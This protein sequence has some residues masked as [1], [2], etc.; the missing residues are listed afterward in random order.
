MYVFFITYPS[1]TNHI[2]YRHLKLADKFILSFRHR[3]GINQVISFLISLHPPYSSLLPV[4]LPGGSYSKLSMVSS[5]LCVLTHL[6]SS[7]YQRSLWELNHINSFSM[8]FLVYLCLPSGALF[9]SLVSFPFSFL[10]LCYLYF[11]TFLFHVVT[12]FW[13]T[14]I[15]NI[16]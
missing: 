8:C 4:H 16:H 7:D 14:P 12:L 5:L 2:I 1:N 6:L 3:P 10:F 11:G 13:W 9:I 15:I